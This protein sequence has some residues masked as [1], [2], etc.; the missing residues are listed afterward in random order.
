VSAEYGLPGNGVSLSELDFQHDSPPVHEKLRIGYYFDPAGIPRPEMFASCRS[1]LGMR[2]AMMSWLDE[3]ARRDLRG[4]VDRRA[5]VEGDV[6]VEPGAIIEPGAHI[7][8]PALICAGARIRSNAYLRD[9]VV[10]GRGAKIGHCTEVTRSIVMARS[11]ATHMVFLGDSIVGSDVNI[12][13]SC[14]TANLRVDRVVTEPA[15]QEISVLVDGRRIPTGQ[16]KF[17]AVIGDRTRIPALLS[18]APGTLLGAGTVIFPR[19]Q[20]GGTFPAHT[21]LR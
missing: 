4:E 19:T 5:I 13:S 16:T 3:N 21:E 14:V 18:L 20:I 10:I 8:G 9:H 11:M 17:G 6:I 7:E 1:V 12:G 2:D 15:T